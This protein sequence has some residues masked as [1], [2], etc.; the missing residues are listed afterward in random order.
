MHAKNTHLLIAGALV[1]SPFAGACDCT[2]FGLD[3]VEQTSGATTTL[4]ETTTTATPTTEPPPTTTTADE[5]TMGVLTGTLTVDP[6]S[7]TGEPDTSSTDTG[8][9]AGQ[10][11][12]GS[13]GDAPP[14]APVLHLEFSAIK[15]FDFSWSAVAGADFYRLLERQNADPDAVF[16]QLGADIFGEVVSWTMPLHLRRQASYILQACNGGGCTDS[17]EVEVDDPLVAA[18]GYIKPNVI[19]MGDQFGYRVDLSSVG[20]T[21][22][23]GAYGEGSADVGPDA[24]PNNN[25][26]PGS[27]AVSV[28]VRD[29]S[30]WSHQ[31]YIKGSNTGGND[32][33]GYRVSLSNDGDTM[34]VSAP[35]EDGSSIGV[36][37]G[38]DN[39]ATN[40]GAVYVFI[41][42]G[43]KWTQQ[44][45]IKA[46]NTDPSDSFGASVALSGDGDTLVIGAENEDSKATGVDGDDGNNDSISAGAVYVFTRTGGVWQQEAYLKASNTSDGDSFG[47]SVAV[48]SAGIMIA[49]GA[50]GEDSFT[51]AV[52]VFEFKN[53]TW[54]Q[55]AYIKA[56]NAD[57]GDHFGDSVA[58][59]AN[60][61]TLAVGAFFEDSGATGVDGDEDSNSASASGAAY[62]FVRAGMAWQQQAY[63]KSGNTRELDT[64]GTSLDISESGDQLVVGTRGDASSSLGVNYGPFDNLKPGSG[65]AY[66]FVRTNDKWTSHAQI[67]AP[68][69]ESTDAFG[70]SVALA[71][72]GETLAVTSAEE[73]S[74]AVG[75]GGDQNDNSFMQ[76][77]A[78]YLY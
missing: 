50:D 65:A 73:R 54:S 22:V 3:P 42:D 37:G 77:G 47:D 48:S 24:D 78:C 19:N 10:T 46:S 6:T 63:I 26:A 44:A 35:F 7:T 61:D 68:N 64:F 49:V 45:Y 9:T 67:K 29:E 17:D 69:A 18:I 12:S 52:Y 2:T 14:E 23:V 70:I 21:L 40:S 74:A 25:D 39:G 1:A 13:S 20:D 58:L 30:K 16:A 8:T 60:A 38:D 62:V 32:H 51:G 72:D 11:S 34:A 59:S 27:G 56:S 76:A 53:S 66:V 33:F 5:T 31:S 36:N 75:I 15:Q 55:Q 4:A 57:F 28:F 71:G 41:R 43:A